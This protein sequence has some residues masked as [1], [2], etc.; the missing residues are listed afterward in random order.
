MCVTPYIILRNWTRSK[1]WFPFYLNSA[2]EKSHAACADLNPQ[3]IAARQHN[4]TCAN[5]NKTGKHSLY[6]VLSLATINQHTSFDL[7]SPT[8]S[9]FL[10]LLFIVVSDD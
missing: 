7:S 10:N 3:H 4:N 8:G 2:H 1:T 9:T 5:S 6:A